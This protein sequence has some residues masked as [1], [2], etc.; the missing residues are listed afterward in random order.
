MLMCMTMD[1]QN[2]TASTEDPDFKTE[3]NLVTKLLS[4]LLLTI[5]NLSLYPYGHT[6]CTNSI[7]Q[8]HSQLSDFLKK[9]KTLKL[10]IER[11]RIIYKEETLSEETPEEGTLHYT[12]FRDGIKWIEFLDG[13]DQKEISDILLIINKYIK[14]SAEPE[15]DIATALWEK[16]FPHIKYEIA[17]FFWGG[18]KAKEKFSD[19]I[20]DK[21]DA[22]ESEQLNYR[23]IEYESDPEIDLSLIMLTPAEETSLKEMI[24]ADNEADLTSYLD[25][26]LDSLLQHKEENNFKKILEALSE[27]F[28]LSLTRK[29][30]VVTRKI[31]Q[32][33]EYVLNIINTELPW[34][35]NLIK[36]FFLKVSTTEYLTALKDNWSKLDPEDADVLRDIFMI[37]DPKVIKTLVSLFTQS[38]PAPLRKMLLDLIILRSSQDTQALEFALNSAGYNLLKQLIKVIVEINSPQSLKYLKKLS[39]HKNQ[40]LYA[41]RQLRELSSWNL[42]V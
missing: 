32:G 29:D 9:Y 5:K 22:P 8:F 16:Y 11:N 41:T 39:N 30:F 24:R 27:E 14:L 15:G 6:I 36:D 37:F 19:M 3:F 40:A 17:E 12:L 25:V 4:V 21:S 18:G 13:I 23:D 7:N 31:L 28:S 1:R 26:L 33:L 38:Q 35:E 2:N 42:N 34:A 10:E 20:S